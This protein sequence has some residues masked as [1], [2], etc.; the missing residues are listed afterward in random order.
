MACRR[1]TL[2]D[3][4]ESAGGN[5]NRSNRVHNLQTLFRANSHISSAQ[6]IVDGYGLWPGI[7]SGGQVEAAVGRDAQASGHFCII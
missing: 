2:I 1:K 4:F 7:F 6:S 3:D 5:P